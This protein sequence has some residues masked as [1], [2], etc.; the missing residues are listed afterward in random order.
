MSH[1]LSLVHPELREAL[2]N[3]A[4][5]AFSADTLPL[6]RQARETML[7]MPEE[8]CPARLGRK[9]YRWVFWRAPCRTG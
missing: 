1:G 4:Q 6:V 2:Q 7:A 9:R 3:F 8:H 5:F